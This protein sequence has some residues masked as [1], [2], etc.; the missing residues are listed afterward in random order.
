MLVVKFFGEKISQEDWPDDGE[1]PDVGMEVKWY[2]LGLEVS[3]RAGKGHKQGLCK[4]A[5]AISGLS[6]RGAIAHFR[7]RDAR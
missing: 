4:V 6:T 5:D 2:C 7:K 1:G 3:T